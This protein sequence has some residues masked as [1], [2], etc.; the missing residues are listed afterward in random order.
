M[1]SSI[2]FHLEEKLHA[3]DKFLKVAGFHIL[4]RGFRKNLA[5]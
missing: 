1:H 3:E 5:L 2:D 4:S